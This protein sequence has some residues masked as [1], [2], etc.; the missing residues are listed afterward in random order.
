MKIII[1]RRERKV[2]GIY[3]YSKHLLNAVLLDPNNLEDNVIMKFQEDKADLIVDLE[4]NLNFKLKLHTSEFKHNGYVLIP[5]DKVVEFIDYCF[6]SKNNL[7]VITDDLKKKYYLKFD[8]NS[9]EKGK[10][11][12]KI[13]KVVKLC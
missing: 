7:N 11:K 1:G 9:L 10:Y 5:D 12:Y 4:F 3:G 13:E 2:L 8:L 6:K